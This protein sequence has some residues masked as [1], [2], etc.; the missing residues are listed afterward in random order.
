MNTELASTSREALLRAFTNAEYRVVLGGETMSLRPG[1]AQPDLDAALGERTWAILTACNPGGER[2][3]G[4]ANHERQRRLHDIVAE[5]GWPAHAGVNRDPDG[6]WPD[7]PSMLIVDAPMR[8]LDALAGRFG[9]AAILAGAP[10]QPARLRL[11][12]GGWPAP[13]PDWAERCER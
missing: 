13:L 6:E 11:Y 2:D 9:Q 8:E 12:G 3:S 5:S 10:G 1:R 7:E 4:E